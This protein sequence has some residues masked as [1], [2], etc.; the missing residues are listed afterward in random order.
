[1]S[2]NS[3]SSTKGADVILAHPLPHPLCAVIAEGTGRT[4]I[5]IYTAAPGM[6]L[7]RLSAGSAAPAHGYRFAETVAQA[8][9]HPLYAPALSWARRELG[10]RERKT[11]TL[12]G[13]LRAG[14]AFCTGTAPPCCRR[15]SPCPTVTPARGTGGRPGTAPGAPMSG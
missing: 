6:L 15:G 3:P 14:N 12:L 4:C 13:A 5:G 7:P 10:M 11:D 8:A 9:M 2:S 1:M